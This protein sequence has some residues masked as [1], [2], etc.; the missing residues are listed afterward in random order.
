MDRC[1]FVIGC[2]K[3]FEVAHL[4]C[5][6]AGN[7]NDF[8]GGELEELIKKLLVATFPWWVDNDGGF[9]CGKVDVFEDFFCAGGEERGVAD[10]V[11]F[12]ISLCPVRGSFRNLDTCDLVKLMG[13]A[14]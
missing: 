11:E 4:G 13:E 1:E 14:E 10:V 5:G 9:I 8:V 7:I 2:E 6:V 3:L 12:G